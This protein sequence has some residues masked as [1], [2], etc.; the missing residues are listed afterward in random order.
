VKQV[1]LGSAAGGG[2][3]Q[4]NCNC[5]VCNFFWQ[6]DPRVR[7]RTQ[8]SL[9]LSNTA[10]SEWVLLNCSPD[11]REQIAQSRFLQPKSAPRHSPIVGVILSNADIDHIGGL[12]SLREQQTLTI[13]ATQEV[14][15]Q[16]AANP[17]FEA[18]NKDVVRY[19]TIE[20]GKSFSPLPDLAVQPFEVPGKVPLYREASEGFSVGRFGNTKGFHVKTP[21]HALS[22]VPGCGAVDSELLAELAETDTLLFDGTLWTDDEMIA[23]GTGQKTGRRMGH[24]PVSGADGTMALLSDLRARKRIFVHMNNTNPLLIDGSPERMEAERHGWTVSYDG[25]EIAP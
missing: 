16:I 2:Y 1:V 21:Q 4:W 17:I 5:R 7:R 13:W 11:I 10:G 20:S 6:S 15:N 22:Y 8:S 9:A 25:M 18:L 23:S 24:V 14:L 19:V 12:I 3:P